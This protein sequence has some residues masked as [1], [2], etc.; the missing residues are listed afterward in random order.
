MLHAGIYLIAK[1][2]PS[3]VHTIHTHTM[4][5]TPNRMVFYELMHRNKRTR[6]PHNREMH[7]RK[8]IGKDKYTI[9]YEWYWGI[10]KHFPLC[11]RNEKKKTETAH[12]KFNHSKY[13]RRENSKRKKNERDAEKGYEV[14]FEWGPQETVLKYEQGCLTYTHTTIGIKIDRRWLNGSTREDRITVFH[15]QNIWNK[16]EANQG[17]PD[18]VKI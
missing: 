13:A 3:N 7:N 1:S 18:N 9:Y 10:A 17:H 16:Q 12:L 8:K 11:I 4:Y 14:K 6:L 2:R 15:G 5:Y